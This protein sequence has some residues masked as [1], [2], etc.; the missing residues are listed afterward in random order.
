MKRKYKGTYI[1]TYKLPLDQNESGKEIIEFLG[2]KEV[3]HPALHKCYKIK[4]AYYANSK[5]QIELG[6]TDGSFVV[7]ADVVEA[8]V[9]NKPS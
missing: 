3:Y 1:E 4:A 5:L 6:A 9:V 2:A 8:V 7:N